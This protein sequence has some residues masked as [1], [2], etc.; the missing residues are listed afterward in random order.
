MEQTSNGLPH[1]FLLLLRG[2]HSVQ[3]LKKYTLKNFN[4]RFTYYFL[5]K[6]KLE[7]PQ[8]KWSLTRN[9]IVKLGPI[10]K[11]NIIYL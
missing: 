2:S 1:A 11:S 3:G 10:Y 8:N 5:N 7:D 4:T 9:A 6:L